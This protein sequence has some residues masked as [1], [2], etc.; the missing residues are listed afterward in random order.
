MSSLNDQLN[1]FKAKVRNAPVL[2]KRIIEPVTGT[3]SVSAANSTKSLARDG[4]SFLQDPDGSP[5]KARGVVYSQPAS[6]GTG[7]HKSTQLVHTIEYLKKC[8]CPVLL[9]DLETYLSTPIEPLLPLLQQH[10]NVR[11]DH[12]AGTALYVSK[13]DVYSADDLVNFLNRQKTMVG[14]P[15]RD[16]KDGWSGAVQ[17]INRLEAENKILVLRNKKDNAPRLVWPNHGGPLVQIDKHFV[18]LWH[19]AKVPSANDLPGTLEKVGLKPSSVDMS[20]VKKLTKTAPEKPKKTSQR[21]K[22]TN[23]HLRGVLKDYGQ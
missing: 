14:I 11:I 4:A 1:S 23:T 16:L 20:R 10:K 19:T 18:D 6:T 21:T 9:K 17:T 22:F 8:E 12:K 5:Q 7:S 3:T 15:V 13:H 2:K